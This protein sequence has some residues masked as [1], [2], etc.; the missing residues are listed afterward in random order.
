V[1]GRGSGMSMTVYLFVSMWEG[2]LTFVC[3]DESGPLSPNMLGMP[4]MN[5]EG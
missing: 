3:D 4:P 1:S 2:G 5:N